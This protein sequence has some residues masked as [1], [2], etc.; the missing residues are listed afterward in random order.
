MS[1]SSER[2]PFIQAQFLEDLEAGSVNLEAP[3]TERVVKDII[4]AY[5]EAFHDSAV[6]IRCGANANVPL[7]FRVLFAIPA[8]VVDIALKHRWVEEDNAIVQLH[9]SINQ[10]CQRAL[11]Q[12][13]FTADKGFEAVWKFL[14]DSFSVDKV[15]GISGMTEGI[16]ANMSRFKALNL[17]NVPIVHLDFRQ[18][19]FSLYFLAQGP[20]TKQHLAD[21]IAMAGAPEPSGQ[22]FS[23]RAY[24]APQMN[25]EVSG[26]GFHP[27]GKDKHIL[28]LLCVPLGTA[29]KLPRHPIRPVQFPI[30]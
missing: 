14:G 3:Y 26:G 30:C 20:L 23:P 27:L 12:P 1:T 7:M 4:E 24:T 21:V 5:G 9:R 25:P 11:D 22:S 2:A 16:R 28:Y 8:D 18:K 15:L 17:T 29:H 19:T 6:Q 13:E 10:E